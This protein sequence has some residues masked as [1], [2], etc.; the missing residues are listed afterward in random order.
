MP[1]QEGVSIF[2]VDTLFLVTM[3][4]YQNNISQYAVV[5]WDEPVFNPGGSFDFFIH[6]YVAPLDGYYQWVVLLSKNKFGK[7]THWFTFHNKIMEMQWDAGFNCMLHLADLMEI[8][9]FLFSVTL[10]E[11]YDFQNCGVQNKRNSFGF[12][13]CSQSKQG[14]CCFPC[15]HFSTILKP[16]ATNSVTKNIFILRISLHQFDLTE[17]FRSVARRS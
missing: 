15:C 7:H 8:N 2:T 6:A 10:Q 14:T 1:H 17:I 4:A 11:F 13:T 3:N 5:P 12:E 9:F 16:R